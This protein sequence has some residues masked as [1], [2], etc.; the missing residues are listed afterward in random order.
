[1]GELAALLVLTAVIVAVVVAVRLEWWRP[2][3]AVV[4]GV[5]IL[6]A[7]T[8]LASEIV[9]IVD[10]LTTTEGPVDSPDPGALADAAAKIDAAQGES[11]FHIELTED[12]L[13]AYLLD[14]LADNPDNP[15]RRVD[16]DVVDEPGG[17]QI[18][19]E[20]LFKSGD[21]TAS[22]AVAPRLRAGSVEIDLLRADMGSLNVPGVAEDALEDL[23]ASIA[24]LN[25][26]LTEARAD[27]QSIVIRDDSLFVTGTTAGGSLI[28]STTVLESLQAQAEAATSATEP[29]AEA[30]GPGVVNG[31]GVDGPSYV[32]ALGD[33]LAANVG[34]QEPRDG[35]VSRFHKAVSDRDGVAYGLRNFGVSGETTG[36][37]IRSGQL[38]AA[39]EFLE[40]NDVSYVTIDIG[41]NNLLGHLGSTECQADIFSAGCTSR[42]DATMAGYADDLTVVLDAVTAAAPEATVVFLTAYNPFSFGFSG[43]EFE[44]ESDRIIA[45]F[46]AIAAGVASARG[47][48]VA[49]GF[50]PMQGTVASTTH[51]V[52][53]QPDIHPVPIGYDVLA[54][55]L[56]AAVP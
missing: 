10:A 21:L 17:G 24:D 52:D 48:L 25:R 29:P 51:M 50:G 6:G 2:W 23:I 5:L 7:G 35:Y 47:V 18:R 15:L 11:G 41:A 12:E 34:V 54:A 27:V 37:M 40:S 33:S 4:L 44:A 43:V 53:A 38:D 36:S 8:V 20:A 30:I 3:V 26:A 49:D 31:T 32:V 42:I 56:L 16:I 1:M 46:N 39:V 9:A 45:Q 22:G 13:T 14:A 28:T 19:F 55:A